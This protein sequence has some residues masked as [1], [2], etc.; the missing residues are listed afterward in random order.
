MYKIIDGM[1]IAQS[2][3][4]EIREKVVTFKAETGCEIG[5]AVVLVGEN[6]ASQI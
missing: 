2:I 3:R 6:P 4:A 5:L 1:A